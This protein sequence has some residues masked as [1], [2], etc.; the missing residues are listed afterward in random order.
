MNYTTAINLERLPEFAKKKRKKVAVE[1]LKIKEK[2]SQVE[3]C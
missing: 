1:D 2:R 3:K